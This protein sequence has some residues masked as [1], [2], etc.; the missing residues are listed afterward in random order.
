MAIWLSRLEIASLR[1]AMTKSE[2]PKSQNESAEPFVF[3][4]QIAFHTS[5][6]YLDKL[7]AC[8]NI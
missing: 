7:P 5:F 3:I 2:S 6:R 4:F 1:L 8:A